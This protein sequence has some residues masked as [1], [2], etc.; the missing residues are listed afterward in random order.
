MLYTLRYRRVE[1]DGRISDWY[2]MSPATMPQVLEEL[3]F[4]ENHYK[5]AAYEISR[6]EAGD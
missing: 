2:L 4:V 1:R 5:V 6:A 3:R